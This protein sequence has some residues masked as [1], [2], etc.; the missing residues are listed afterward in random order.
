M[1]KAISGPLD[2]SIEGTGVVAGRRGPDGILYL[3]CG[4]GRSYQMKG[5]TCETWAILGRLRETHRLS[6]REDV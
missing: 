1:E 2:F 6:P 5:A 4:L 3:G